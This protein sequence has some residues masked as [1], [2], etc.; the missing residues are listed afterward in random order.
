MAK[1]LKS[2]LI[3]GVTGTVAYLATLILVWP[4]MQAATRHHSPGEP[5]PAVPI[6]RES[7]FA[8]T[9]ASI[10]VNPEV[11]QLAAELKKEKLALD[12]REKQIKQLEERLQ[13][14][15][16]EIEVVAESVRKMQQD[17][18][19]QITRVKQEEVVNLKRLSKIYANM[20]PPTAAA[21]MKEMEDMAIAKI[22][23]G[24]KDTET[25]GILQ[26]LARMGPAEA[27]RAAE[28]SERLR[29]ALANPTPT[30]RT[31]P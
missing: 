1:H 17:F 31:S 16:G 27:R 4:P 30:K 19:K 25:A 10:T 8:A 18:D 7:I 5:E 3:A 29:L 26:E 23:V 13:A 2:G 22:L 21:I 28:L 20:E 11:D 14:E 24:M 15:R 6:Q 12:E 9:P